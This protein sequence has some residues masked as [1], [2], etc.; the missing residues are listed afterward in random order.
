MTNL[1]GIVAKA[2]WKFLSE[3]AKESMSTVMAALND[4]KTSEELEL[5]TW[6]TM[7]AGDED[8]ALAD[9]NYA[10]KFRWL[11]EPSGPSGGLAQQ[12][13]A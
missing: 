4:M 12:A 9:A 10:S 1:E 8:M 2:I 11:C 3:D 6:Q 13:K 5:A 7:P